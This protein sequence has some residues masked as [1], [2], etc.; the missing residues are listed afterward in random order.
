ENL[1]SEHN[2]EQDNYLKSVADVNGFVHEEDVRSH[3]ALSSYNLSGDTLCRLATTMGSLQVEGYYMRAKNYWWKY[4]R[5]PLNYQEYRILCQQTNLRNRPIEYNENSLIKKSEESQVGFRSM[6]FANF[7]QNLFPKKPKLP[8]TVKVGLKSTTVF[9]N[10][11]NEK[12]NNAKKYAIKIVSSEELKAEQEK[13]RSKISN[14]I[15][16]MREKHRALGRK[17]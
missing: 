11:G 12:S 7:V 9:G 16:A 8:L 10:D 17:L 2:L 14:R 1:F 3:Y 6:R 13:V 5:Y 15:L 4:I